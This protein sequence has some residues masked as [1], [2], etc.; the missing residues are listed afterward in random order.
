MNIAITGGTGFLGRELIDLLIRNKSYKIKILGQRDITDYNGISYNTTD[1]SETDLESLLENVDIIIHLAAKRDLE[2]SFEDLVGNVR[3]TDNIF[4]VMSKLRIQKMIYAS[5]ISVYSNENALPWNENQI[6]KP[7]SYYGLSKLFGE[8]IAGLYYNSHKI[9]TISLRIAQI[10]GEGERKGYMMNTFIDNAFEKK[11]LS[12]WGKS[13]AKREYVYVKD[14]ARAIL[15]A[16]DK[17]SKHHG[18]INIGSNI[19]HTI[20]EFASSINNFFGNQENLEYLEQKQ[21]T[22]TDSYINKSLASQLLNYNP[23]YDL[24]LALDEIKK[25]KESQ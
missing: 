25:I 21:E 5:S 3:I 10:L 11:K 2:G 17:I 6:P 13:I 20:L 24:T 1:Y 18:P 9:K 15:L 12:I 8:N 16:M 14:V 23:N 4:R 19:I 22:I 7:K